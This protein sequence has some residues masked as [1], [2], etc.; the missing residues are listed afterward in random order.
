MGRVGGPWCTSLR[1][2]QGPRSEGCSARPGAGGE[3]LDAGSPLTL[4]RGAPYPSLFPPGYWGLLYLLTEPGQLRVLPV[5]E[6]V[7]CGSSSSDLNFRHSSL[8][9]E[10]AAGA[11]MSD[12]I[13]PCL[14]FPICT[15]LLRSPCRINQVMQ[16]LLFAL[17]LAR[18]EGK[19][20]LCPEKAQVLLG[21]LP[22]AGRGLPRKC[23]PP[24]WKETEQPLEATPLMGSRELPFSCCSGV[25][26][27][28]E[29]AAPPSSARGGRS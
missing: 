21:P 25:S 6:A 15:Y 11:R 26:L 22:W 20:S 2:Q 10:A 9:I 4:F 23:L 17:H 7:D 8:I 28:V 16:V 18:C 27:L 3:G 24:P 1:S 12:F 14:G 19:S 29:R 5:Q 13:S